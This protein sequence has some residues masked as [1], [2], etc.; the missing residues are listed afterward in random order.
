MW[1]EYFTF[2]VVWTAGVASMICVVHKLEL[3]RTSKL[4]IVG[5]RLWIWHIIPQITSEMWSEPIQPIPGVSA[6]IMN[7]N[8]DCVDI[9]GCSRK[10]WTGKAS[11]DICHVE[12]EPKESV[13][14]S[15]SHFCQ[16]SRVLCRHKSH[17][18]PI[19]LQ[20]DWLDDRTPASTHA[21]FRWWKDFSPSKCCQT[22]SSLTRMCKFLGLISLAVYM[23]C[24]P[25]K[26]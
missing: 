3:R 10:H 11:N 8:L 18:L 23:N 1:W 16:H 6:V 9:T 4:I 20:Q 7:I 15:K 14:K 17:V 26:P 22:Y 13:W 12:K 2:L 21:L 24:S 5:M 19:F 25:K